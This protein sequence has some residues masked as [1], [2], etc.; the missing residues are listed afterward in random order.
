[1]VFFATPEKSVGHVAEMMKSKLLS[2]IWVPWEDVGAYIEKSDAALIGPGFMRFKSEMGKKIEIENGNSA[3]LESREITERLLK[4]FPDKRWVIDAGSLQTMEPEWI[5]QGAILTPNRKEFERLFKSRVEERESGR[6][7]VVEEM[8]KKYNCTITL[9][10]SEA[11]VASPDNL[12]IVKGGNPGLTKGGSGDVL[13]GLTVSLLAKNDPFLAASGASFLEKASADELYKKVG[14]NYNA[15]DLA[16][17]I[18]QV[19]QRLLK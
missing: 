19:Y 16:D 9:K 8:A 2:F 4:K 11:I 3:G 13:A 12:V 5:P 15:D 1:M 18:P 17:T 14:T 7:E 10:G 6:V